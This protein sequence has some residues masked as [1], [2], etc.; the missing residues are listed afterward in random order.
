MKKLHLPRLGRA[1]KIIRNLL[2]C[3]PLAVLVWAR[4]GCPMPTT[5]LEFRRL[6]GRYLL[7]HS[8]ILWD[9]GTEGRG[10]HGDLP[11]WQLLD[12][13]VIGVRGGVAT[14]A[15]IDRPDRNFFL[16]C[17]PLE[18]AP[19][20]VPT[21][22]AAMSYGGLR[23]E[24]LVFFGVPEETE[25]VELELECLGSD[26]M[27]RV[28]SG[29]GRPLGDGRWLC[30]TSPGPTFP[31]DWYEGGSYVLRMYDEAGKLLL[32]RAGVLPSPL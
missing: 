11:S 29:D 17:Y 27:N 16:S 3:L 21:P 12:D 1:G 26:G 32:E 14:A 20:P 18:E 6:E 15:M 10:S 4:S 25:R 8:E 24:A 23:M 5:Q 31:W 19:F 22:D 30:P 9:T 13:W 28:W 7:P 2:L